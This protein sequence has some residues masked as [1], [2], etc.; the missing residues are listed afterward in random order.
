M[1]KTKRNS[2]QEE[3]QEEE[4]TKTGVERILEKQNV[5][6]KEI[7]QVIVKEMKEMM[8]TILE[9]KVEAIQNE[10]FG[11]SKKMDKM[12]KEL[13]QIDDENYEIMERCKRLERE[14]TVMKK[15]IEELENKNTGRELEIVVNGNGDIEDE[16]Q[17]KEILKLLDMKDA[18]IEKVN[19]WKT[20]TGKVINVKCDNKE[21]MRQILARRRQL[22]NREGQTKIY[23]NEVLD[24]E[25]KRIYMKAR[26]C[27]REGIIEGVTIRDKRVGIYRGNKLTMVEDIEE[28][29]EL[30]KKT[31]RESK[32]IVMTGTL[33]FRP[34][35]SEKSKEGENKNREN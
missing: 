27:F 12:E 8:K 20:R 2:I 14:N 7:I 10:M 34:P 11:M 15:K 6:L 35:E 32:G 1:S 9:G 28:L 33:K 22:K 29:D 21:I 25:T 18:K 23:V 30:I 16:E 13:K 24:T 31:H 17:I 19:S 3:G 4:M 26:W 5:M